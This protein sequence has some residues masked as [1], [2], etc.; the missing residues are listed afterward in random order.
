MVGTPD[1]MLPDRG[2]VAA[3]EA[4][5][6]AG[7]LRVFDGHATAWLVAQ[8]VLEIAAFAMIFVGVV[9]GS[10]LVGRWVWVAVGLGVLL[11]AWEGPVSRRAGAEPLRWPTRRRVGV[12]TA[13]AVAILA[14]AALTDASA[15]SSG[16]GSGLVVGSAALAVCYVAAPVVRWLWS[17]RRPRGAATWPD[18]AQAYAVLSVLSRAQWVHPDRLAVLTGLSRDRCDEWLRACAAR[19]FATPAARRAILMRHAEI[20]ASGR[21]RLARWNAELAARAALAQPWTASTAP[22]SPEVSSP[23]SSSDVT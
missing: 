22:T 18:G 1:E 8:R 2:P 9:F 15:G 5:R 23:R 11:F 6:A 10:I 13:L 16:N 20:T 21:T 19:G 17:R 4:L 14:G 12:A 3:A 7:E